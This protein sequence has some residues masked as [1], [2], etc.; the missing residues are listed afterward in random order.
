MARLVR[1]YLIAWPQVGTEKPVTNVSIA[2]Q[3]EHRDVREGKAVTDYYEPDGSDPYI[4]A[5]N[6]EEV[7]SD[8]EYVKMEL[9]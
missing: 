3:E 8:A 7:H 4:K 2:Q 5:I 1:G 9:P 6:E